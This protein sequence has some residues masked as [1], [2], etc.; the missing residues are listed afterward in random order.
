MWNQEIQI[1]AKQEFEF[2][3]IA[4]SFSS[5]V[6]EKA[7]KI[8]ENFPRPIS[9]KSWNIIV[10]VWWI[11]WI[12]LGPENKK[13][14]KMC[15][16]MFQR[17]KENWWKISYKI[18]GNI[19]NLATLQRFGSPSKIPSKTL[20][21]PRKSMKVS[22]VQSRTNFYSKTR[23]SGNRNL[24]TKTF[25]SPK[26]LMTFRWL[27]RISL[28]V[29]VSKGSKVKYFSR[30]KLNGIELGFLLFLISFFSSRLEKSNFKV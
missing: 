30:S 1:F 24:H 11:L 12:A 25:K 21:K 27:I 16:W 10:M 7:Q 18:Y 6:R 13:E 26:H 5:K 4:Y 15:R 8:H 23:A 29:A 9:K 14:A 2:R 28:T 19:E 3:F 22:F 20:G 17:M